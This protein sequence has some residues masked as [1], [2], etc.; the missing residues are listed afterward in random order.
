MWRDGKHSKDYQFFD[1][2]ISEQFQVG[3]TGVLIHKYIGPPTDGP[4]GD[5]TQ[6]S[7]ANQ[8]EMNI[9]DLLFLENR[10][11][12]YD[13]D[14]YTTR[15]IYTVSDHDFDLSQFGLFLSNGTIFINFHLNDLVATLGRKLMS[16]DVLELPHL[17]DYNTT[18]DTIP[19]ALKRYYVVSDAKWPTEGFSPTWFPHLWRAKCTPLVNSQEYKDI[20]DQIAQDVTGNANANVTQIS[21]IISTIDTLTAINDSIIVQAEYDVPKSGYDSS[22]LYTLPFDHD[23]KNSV[24]S[25]VYSDRGLGYFIGNVA[26]NFA[27]PEAVDGIVATGNVSLFGNGAISNVTITN[28]GFGYVAVPTVTFTGGNTRQAV[29]TA[30]LTEYNH[31]SDPRVARPDAKIEGYLVGDGTAPNGITVAAGTAFPE[32]PKLGDY[33]LRL[34]YLPNRLFRF[35]GNRWTKLEDA[36]RAN[37]TPGPNNTTLKST[38]I[39]NSSTY[40]DMHGNVKQSRQALNTIFKPG[41]DN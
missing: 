33:Y 22:V 36:V 29:A 12:K 26:V 37:L 41:A 40:L 7:Y 17:K 20:L 23:K 4:T 24:T 9:Q 1:K 2:T 10:D 11:R 3:G 21:N 14:V 13:P 27:A 25:L 15:G 28:P 34:D 35:D 30:V 39:N 32:N 38:F 6:P 5:A 16:G 18:S 8:S 31:P 19:I